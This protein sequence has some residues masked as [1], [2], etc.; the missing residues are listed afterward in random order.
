MRYYRNIT[1]PRRAFTLVEVML[2]VLIIGIGVIPVISLFLQSSRTVEKG[3]EML[4]A[5]IA[6]QNILDRVKSDDFI[7]DHI[8]QT[9]PVPGDKLPGVELPRFFAEKYKATAEV[10]IDMGKMEL[11]RSVPARQK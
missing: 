8:G 5:T 7:W 6:A 2:A 3:G 1:S 9:F 10:A 11:R 4:A